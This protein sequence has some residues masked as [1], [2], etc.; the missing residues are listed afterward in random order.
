MST[1]CIKSYQFNNE[2]L[3]EVQKTPNGKNWPVVYLIHD[4]KNLYIG[5]TTSVSTR[6]NQHLQNPKKKDLETIEII[7]DPSFNK[8]VVLDYEQRL[9]KYCSVDKKFKNILNRNKGQ[10]SSHDYFERNKYRSNFNVLWE[11]LRKKDLANKSLSI[12]EN[13]NIFKFSPYNSLTGEQNEVCVSVINDILDS[14]SNEKNGISLVDGCSGTGKTVLAISIVNSLVNAINVDDE[15][16]EANYDELV[17]D[18]D[19]SKKE[20]LLKLKKHIINERNGKPFKIG[21]VY[22][23]PGLRKTVSNV[24]HECGNG[25]TK[26]MVIKPNDVTKDDY[27]IIIVDESHRLSK[28]KNLP[29]YK[30]FDKASER[31]GL[32]PNNTNQLEWMLKSAKHVV[33]FYDRYQ[34]V[35]S[36]NIPYD[37]YKNTLN[38][39]GNIKY[40]KLETQMRCEGGATYI[41]YVKDILN[42]KKTDFE[43]ISNYDFL[44]FDDVNNMVENIRKKDEQFGLSK[45]VAGFSWEWKTKPEKKVPNNLAHYDWLVHNDKYDILIENY[46]YIWNLSSED[47]IAREDS[48]YTIGCIHTSQGYDMNYVGVI[49][50]KEIDY[51]PDTNS[52]EIIRDEYQDRKIKDKTNDEELKTLIINTYTTILGR[53][54]KGCYVYVCNENLRNYLKKFIPIAN[55]VTLGEE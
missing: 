45:V 14:F 8:S 54:I 7:F 25:L 44:M 3:K 47:W 12:I 50:G 2:G 17:D 26:S 46:K 6:M 29:S 5:E 10:Q 15:L 1:S 40:H 38:K 43:K 28:R 32:K 24:F 49:F 30:L 39:Y 42:C 4:K 35:K 55:S 52:I 53:G 31:V 41:D 20:T 16:L 36:S 33:L 18:I 13:D 9:I 27:D 22:P 48:R 23:M 11:E 51:N 34:C 21:L 19:E 37:E